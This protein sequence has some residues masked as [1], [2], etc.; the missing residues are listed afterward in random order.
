[1]VAEKRL[2]NELPRILAFLAP[3]QPQLAGVVVESTYYGRPGIMHALSL[4]GVER[5]A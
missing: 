2:P 3:W 5:A 4:G 1:V